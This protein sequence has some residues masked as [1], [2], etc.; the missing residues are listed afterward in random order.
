MQNSLHTTKNLVN[1][2]VPRYQSSICSE[3]PNR[4]G[5]VIDRSEVH[6]AVR[7]HLLGRRRRWR[8]VGDAAVTP[9]LPLPGVLQLAHLD[10]PLHEGPEEGVLVLAEALDDAAGPGVVG[11]ERLVGVEEAAEGDEVLEVAVVED[12]RG[13][14]HAARDLLVAA[15]GAERVERAAVACV[16]VRVGAAGAGLVVEAEDDGEAAGLPDGMRAGERDEVGDAEVE[17]GEEADERAG[18]GARARHDAVRVLLARRQAVLAPEPHLPGGP[19][20]LWQEKQ[21]KPRGQ[22]CISTENC[23]ANSH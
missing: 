8:A 19:T 14:V 13:G 5:R 4:A 9:Y 23:N 3:T 1:I 10:H 22:T 6:D 18:V 7:R 12:A 16:H 15:P 17:P 2:S 21:S 11:E 20:G